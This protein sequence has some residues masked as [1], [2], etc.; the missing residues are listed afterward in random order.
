MTTTVVTLRNLQGGTFRPGSAFEN[1]EDQKMAVR[2][3]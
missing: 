3:W 2:P 1:I